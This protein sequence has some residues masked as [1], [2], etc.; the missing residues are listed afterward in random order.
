MFSHTSTRAI[1][2]RTVM[3]HR[4]LRAKWLLCSTRFFAFVNSL[5]PQSATAVQRAF[6]LR[7]NIQPP[8]KK[9]ICRWNHQFEEIGCLCKGESSGRPRVSEEN[10]RRIQENFER[11][12]SKSARRA[13]REL[14]IP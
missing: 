4:Q 6:L 9:S 8:T 2:L 5:K 14:G 1:V 3:Q 11:S 7:F 10:V 12:S 13:S